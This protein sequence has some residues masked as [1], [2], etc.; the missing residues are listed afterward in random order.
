MLGHVNASCRR[1]CW[2]CRDMNG[3]LA[4]FACLRVAHNIM[5]LFLLTCDTE[6]L[7]TL[8]ISACPLL[9]CWSVKVGKSVE[10]HKGKPATGYTTLA[11]LREPPASLEPILALPVFHEDVS[12]AYLIDKVKTRATTQLSAHRV[13]STR[14][15]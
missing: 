15:L 14:T 3:A 12:H 11:G 10:Q 13:D 8:W 9:V 7:S 1:D 2:G 6:H 5:V 4:C